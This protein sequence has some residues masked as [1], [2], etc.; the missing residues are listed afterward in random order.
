MTGL[1]ARAARMLHRPDIGQRAVLPPELSALS[2]L[3]RILLNS[4]LIGGLLCLTAFTDRA[5][6]LAQ[7][8]VFLALMALV[9]WLLLCWDSVG[10][11]LVEHPVALAV[12]VLLMHVG[13]VVIGVDTPFLY[14]VAGSAALVGLC[15]G[16]RG[17]QIFSVLLLS[18]WYLAV[19]LSPPAVDSTSALLRVLIVDP[20][21]VQGVLFGGVALRTLLLRILRIELRLRAESHRAASAQE[22]ARLAREM[23]DTVSKSLYGLAMIAETLPAWVERDPARA[24]VHALELA[25][26][27]RQAVAEA[28][29]ILDVMR[30]DDL[31]SDLA[32]TVT[33]YVRA[34][35]GRCDRT[36]TV[37]A[38]PDV[39]L[40]PGSRYEVLAVL[41]EALENAARHTPADARVVVRLWGDLAWAELSVTDTGAGFEVPGDLVVLQRQGH[42]GLVGMRERA[43]RTGGVLTVRS[44]GE[45]TTVQ[46]RVPTS[47][48]SRDDELTA[49]DLEE[50]QV[51][52]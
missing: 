23:H 5:A 51:T 3:A 15:L 1:T 39:V 16:L 47:T 46:L 12:D 19:S 17:A 52:V 25:M 4:R 20:V 27:S 35:A 30:A 37:E 32:T 29:R 43:G 2:S 38:S 11:V 9:L 14:V 7:V 50:T 45:G 22:R 21:L 34:W 6:S 28:R 13:L 36:A 18:G 49:I 40:G 41:G 24:R 48:G 33:D 31:V 26:A 42:Y 8:G 44:C 10:P